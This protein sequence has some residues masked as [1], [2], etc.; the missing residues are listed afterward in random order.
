MKVGILFGINYVNNHDAQLKGCITDVQNMKSYLCEKQNF[1]NVKIYTDENNMI[2]TSAKNIV[3]TIY[4]WAI[5]SWREHI[6]VIYFHFSGHGTHIHDFDSD[7][8]D[9]R[10]ECFVPCDYKVSGVITDDLFKKLFKYFNYRTKV[11]CVFDCCH[12]GTM[13][14][15][16]YK[17]LLNG[18]HLIENTTSKCRANILT[19]SGC[20]DV[21]TSADAFNVNGN[22][23]FSGALTS[24][25]LSVLK[26]YNQP[27]MK[28]LEVV[29]KTRDVLNQKMFRQIPQLCSS[30]RI[31]NNTLLF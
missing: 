17:W 15:L 10:D 19:I 8:K 28:C 21:Q 29:K 31:D 18:D 30:F 27:D 23:E 24:C 11:I 26:E 7:E 6:D 14:D 9:H 2:D 1:N 25:L 12:S 13:G 16:R 22:Y 4:K 5:K 3:H 20:K